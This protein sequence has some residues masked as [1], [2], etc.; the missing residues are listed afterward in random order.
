MRGKSRLGGRGYRGT[1]SR[2]TGARRVGA[3]GGRGRVRTAW[4]GAG[5]LRL[6]KFHPAPLPRPGVGSGAA[7]A[8]LAACPAGPQ[9]RAGSDERWQRPLGRP[10]PAGLPALSPGPGLAPFEAGGSETTAGSGVGAVLPRLAVHRHM[11][12]PGP[13]G[14]PLPCSRPEPCAAGGPAAKGQPRGS[15]AK[16]SIARRGWDGPRCTSGTAKQCWTKL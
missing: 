15:G 11:E 16:S 8:G 9:R 6:R 12:L 3:R 2:P 5:K 4:P 13:A 14:L 1:P 7:L 10:G